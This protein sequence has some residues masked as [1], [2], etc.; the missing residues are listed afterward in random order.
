M[1]NENA[2]GKDNG[3]PT[4]KSPITA[5]DTKPYCGVI[6][7]I[8]EC[9]GLS[10]SHWAEVKEILF[11]AVTQAGFEPNLVSDGDDVTIIHKRIVQNLYEAPIVV[12]DVSGRNAN[13]MFELG[14]RLTF[15]KPTVIVKDDKT[16]RPFDTGNIQDIEYRRDLRHAA[17]EVFIKDLVK[18]LRATHAAGR[19]PNHSTFLKSF[20]PYT[21]PKLEAKEVSKEQFFLEQLNE[22]RKEIRDLGIALRRPELTTASAIGGGMRS[23]SYDAGDDGP[24]EQYIERLIWELVDEK[25]IPEV[26]V[27]QLRGIRKAV[28][29]ELSK[30]S[31]PTKDLARDLVLKYSSGEGGPG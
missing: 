1:G 10:A 4:S 22:V 7:P 5:G 14:M 17:V 31:A 30:S 2:S 11:E 21:V 6:M 8:S 19:D 16:A 23:P 15:D 18:K 24:M 26:T 12:C 28:R 13:V 29:R 20:G 3:D 27:L 25:R 9:E